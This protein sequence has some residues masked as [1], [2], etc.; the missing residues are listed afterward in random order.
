MNNEN[1]YNMR[2]PDNYLAWSI[3]T[4]IL[5]CLPLGIVAIIKSG[6]VDSLWAEGRHDE[7]IQTAKDAKKWCIFGVAGCAIFYVL[8]ILFIIALVALGVFAD[9]NL[10]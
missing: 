2:K 8:Y 3:L 6:K 9:S 1:N 5:C 10:F 4:T 7:A